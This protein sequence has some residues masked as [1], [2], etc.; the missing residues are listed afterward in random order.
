MKN[1]NV[2]RSSPADIHSRK[3]HVIPLAGRIGLQQ[4]NLHGRES[5][6]ENLTG[7]C[8]TR[9]PTISCDRNY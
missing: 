2:R 7:V 5:A 3:P 1:C 6:T 9:H 4:T 8:L